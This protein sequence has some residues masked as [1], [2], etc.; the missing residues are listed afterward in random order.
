MIMDNKGIHVEF[1]ERLAII[2]LDR[3]DRKNSFNHDMWNA[4]D[5]AVEKVR[6]SMPRA[7]IITGAGD[8]VFSSGFDV[9][10]DN[11]LVSGLIESVKRNDRKPVEV[12]IRKIRTTVDRLVSLPVP[13]IAAVNGLAYGGGAEL[14]V[15]CDMRIM[16]PDAVICFSEVSLGLMPDW[17]GGVALARLAGTAVAA[18]LILSGKKISAQEAFERGMINAVSGKG[19]ALD[20]AVSLGLAIAKNGPRAVRFALRCIRE[21]PALKLDEALELETSLASELIASGECMH[22]ISA[23]LSKKEP[24]FPDP[25]D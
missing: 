3:Q 8:R 20:E 21:S 16:D 10:P 7:V 5:S 18:E 2:T 19:R 13:V 24:E 15:R 6:A 23:F 9:N 4:L 14:A 1:R 17:G 12:M 25:A 11:T 22:G